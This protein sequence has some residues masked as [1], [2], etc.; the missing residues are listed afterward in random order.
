M[1][2]IKPAV[3]SLA[4]PFRMNEGMDEVK[5]VKKKPEPVDGPLLTERDKIKLERRKRKDD[6]QREVSFNSLYTHMTHTYISTCIHIGS[7]DLRT[8]NR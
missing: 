7:D 2:K 3:R 1:I 5:V 8:T 6:R 4:T